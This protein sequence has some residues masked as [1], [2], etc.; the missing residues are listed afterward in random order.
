[1]LC[2]GCDFHIWDAPDCLTGCNF[3]LLFERDRMYLHGATGR[4]G[5]V[6]LSVTGDM[7]LNVD[8]GSYRWGIGG[9]WTSMWTQAGT[10]RILRGGRG[11]RH[12]HM[13]KLYVQGCGSEPDQCSKGGAGTSTHRGCM[14]RGVVRAWS[15]RQLHVE[16]LNWF[17]RGDARLRCPMLHTCAVLR[18]TLPL[19]LPLTWP[20]HRAPHHTAPCRLS[21]T[22]PGV[23]V[24][25]LR[26]TLGVRPVP[27]PLSGAARGVV[28]CTGPLEK[29]VFSGSAVGIR[30]RWVGG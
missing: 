17:T 26:A 10:A 6:P 25:A 3:D 5:A 4:F 11:C 29:P 22:V 24:A 15:V 21:S 18:L 20:A 23:E 1:M 12:A 13:Q 30:P 14:C 27:V 7:D 9:A 19:P 2:R 8:T 28:H 16:M